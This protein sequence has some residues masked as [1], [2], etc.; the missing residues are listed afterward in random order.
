M[1]A[2]LPMNAMVRLGT[3][4]VRGSKRFQHALLKIK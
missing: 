4:I 3:E 2:N 1:Y